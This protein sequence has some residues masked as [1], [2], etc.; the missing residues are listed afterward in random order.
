MYICSL[1]TENCNLSVPTEAA[2]V[3]FRKRIDGSPSKAEATVG[4][5]IVKLFPFYIGSPKN[6]TQ[7]FRTVCDARVIVVEKRATFF[8]Y[9]TLQ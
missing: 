3:L 9:A 5:A 4:L 6:R 2:D 1:S 7:D 8:L